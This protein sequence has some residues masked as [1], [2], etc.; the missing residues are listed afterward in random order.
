MAMAA[1]NPDDLLRSLVDALAAQPGS[2]ARQ[3]AGALS[4]SGHT[5]TKSI[6]NSTLYGNRAVFR[7]EKTTPP[8]WYLR[9]NTRLTAVPDLTGVSSS[10]APRA[11]PRPYLWQAEALTAWREAGRQGVIEAVTGTGK[12]VVGIQAIAES[13][14]DGGRATVIVPKIDLL[15]QWVT[16]IRV[17]LPSARLAELG[18]G[19]Y[20]RLD[21]ADVIVAVVNSAREYDLGDPGRAGLLVADECHGYGSTANARALDERYRRRLGLTATLERNDDGVDAVLVPY[22]GGTCYRIG[23]ERAIRDEVTAHFKVAQV[24]VEFPAGDR[25]AYDDAN[26]KANKA[27]HWLISQGYAPAEPFGEFMRVVSDLAQGGE[28]PATW[29]AR[30]FLAGFTARRQILAETPTKQAHLG[31]LVPALRAANRSIVFTQTIDAAE[32]AAATIRSKGLHSATVHSKLSAAERAQVLE[33]FGDG[34]IP[35]LCAPQV[36]DEGIDVPE[37]DLA[38]ILASSR[39]KRQ[40][41]Q[42]MGRV[43][44]RKA[45]NRLARFVVMHVAGTSEDPA[46]GAHGAFLEEIDGVADEVRHFPV[47]VDPADVCAY[48]GTWT[49]RRRPGPPRFASGS[50]A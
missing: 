14:R 44:R 13:V 10:P 23:F 46:S 26:E 47:G 7:V 48:L 40:M 5:P 33:A 6:I 3:L 15:R 16:R 24:A 35:V 28:G 9:T 2:T 19:S 4:A 37:A 39:T 21:A 18:G 50:P 49:P 25:L 38:V 42:R 34:R 12:T 30:A 43:L 45:D 22:F 1:D 29:K 17:E 31:H 27:Q 36:L 11:I 8:R 41:I 32:G 20:D